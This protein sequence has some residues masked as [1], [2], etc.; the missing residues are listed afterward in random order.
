MD[1]VY[2]VRVGNTEGDLTENCA[3]FTLLSD[4][5]Q[6]YNFLYKD[7]EVR[8]L[9]S[10]YPASESLLDDDR[11]GVGGS[12]MSCSPKAGQNFSFPADLL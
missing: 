6:G 7:M 3:L 4:R 9:T 12:P 8:S 5:S 1:K 10:N 2:P 11:D